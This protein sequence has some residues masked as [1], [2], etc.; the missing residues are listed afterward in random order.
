MIL[1]FQEDLGVNSLW[2]QIRM[3]LEFIGYSFQGADMLAKGLSR[4]GFEPCVLHGGKGQDAREYALQALKDGT[5]NILV[6]TDVAGRGE[7]LE[8][9]ENENENHYDLVLALVTCF[10]ETECLSVFEN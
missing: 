7:S 1:L 9:F 2:F 10:N 8:R 4:L 3:F 5:K 6:A